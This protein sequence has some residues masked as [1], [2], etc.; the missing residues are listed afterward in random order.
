MI[1]T[2]VMIYVYYTLFFILYLLIFLTDSMSAKMYME[3]RINI[4]ILLTQDSSIHSFS[5]PVQNATIPCHSQELFPFLPVICFSLPPIS[6][7]YSYIP[8]LHLVI[9]FLVY[10]SGLL[11]PNSY[12]VLF[13]E[14]Y[15]LPFSV[16]SE[17]TVI[18]LTLLSLLW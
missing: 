12:I 13:W 8:S 17:T 4:I 15:F 5:W 1:P 14:F 10:L 18:Y 6:T 2:N 7:N 16:H 3:G 11:F 9:C